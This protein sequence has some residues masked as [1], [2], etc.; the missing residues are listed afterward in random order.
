MSFPMNKYNEK[1]E[2]LSAMTM[3]ELVPLAIRHG[4]AQSATAAK[5][6]RKAGLVEG[7]ARVLIEID[8]EP[9]PVDDTPDPTHRPTKHAAPVTASPKLPDTVGAAVKRSPRSMKTAAS[10]KRNQ[11]KHRA[12]LGR[13]RSSVRARA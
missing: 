13:L 3:K 10:R 4:V 8:V 9:E 12:R 2:E 11:R 5:R 7:L 6:M 1:T